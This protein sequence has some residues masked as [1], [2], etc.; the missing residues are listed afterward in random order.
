MRAPCLVRFD[1]APHLVRLSLLLQ[2]GGGGGQRT[3]ETCLIGAAARAGSPHHEQPAD[4]HQH[5]HDRDTAYQRRH[6]SV[7]H[8]F[9]PPE[10][11]KGSRPSVPLLGPG[12][13]P[14]KPTFRRRPRQ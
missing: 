11:V 4:D 10:N 6:I 1:A 14:E 2:G 5:G 3:A 13:H 8:A 12:G 9:I 7:I